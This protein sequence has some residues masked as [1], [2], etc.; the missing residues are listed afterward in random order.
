MKQF[1]VG[2]IIFLL[3]VMISAPA[4]S[5]QGPNPRVRELQSKKD[6]IV[7]DYLDEAV[8]DSIIQAVMEEYHIPG[9]ATSM[10][11][12]GEVIWTGTYGYASFEHA[13]MVTDSTLFFL[14][15]ASNAFT[16]TALMQLWDDGL[17]DLD[18]DINEYLPQELVVRNPS[19]P[20]DP[21][22][23]RMLLTHTS[24]IDY[25][26][27][28]QFNLISW[29]TDCPVPLDS[30]LINYF[31]PGGD[32]YSYGPFNSWAPGMGYEHSF[33][34]YA[35]IGYLVEILADTSFA[36]YCQENIF[37]PLG[38]NKTALFLADLDTNHIAMPYHYDGS[39]Y[40]PY[41]YYGLAA[42]PGEQVR[43]SIAQLARFLLAFMNNG[44]LEGHRILNSAT[45]DS[46]TIVQF[47]VVHDEMGL[48]WSIYE[49]QG[50]QYCGLWG[51][52][53]DSRAAIDYLTDKSLGGV[54]LANGGDWDGLNIIYDE[55]YRFA[56]IFNRIYGY[57]V[58][59]SS[60]Y[61]EKDSGTLNLTNRFANPNQHTF[62][63]QAICISTD[64]TVIDSVDLYDDGDHNDGAAG[65]GIWGNTI[66]PY[67]EEK[68]FRVSISTTD[69]VTEEIFA[70]H[71]LTRFTTIGPITFDHFSCM[72]EDTIAN[73]G[74]IVNMCLHLAN[75][76]SSTEA[77]DIS[78]KISSDDPG[79]DLYN[80]PTIL[81]V[82]DIAAGG[83]A[84]TDGAFTFEVLKDSLEHW[85]TKFFVD[86]AS[87][88]YYFW[89]DTFFVYIVS[90]IE[91]SD[92]NIP[93]VFSLDQNYP[94]PFNPSTTIEFAIPK[95]EFVSIKIYNLLGQEVA[96][97]V[98]QTLK[99]GFYK[100]EW[101]ASDLSS[102]VYYYSIQAGDF[103][104]VKKM[105]LIR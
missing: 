83:T 48:S 9:L 90:G 103:Q 41:G 51:S 36:A 80:E 101:N 70:I 81:S 63:A 6:I 4:F 64:N 29:G 46:M 27:N 79:I 15:G 54:F 55:L 26:W 65:D 38:M 73:Y 16:G 88:G 18:D 35:L 34:G 105:V 3:M 104:D 33:G 11:R 25:D 30:F 75:T 60:N 47:P 14:A 52:L 28:L 97:L 74:D 94:N 72:G 66:G 22:T 93:T 89:K 39:N 67:A 31:M 76:G 62:N 56:K 87:G 37:A 77:S 13:R 10:I 40:I 12:E 98:S 85:H 58:A 1:T 2:L 84:S 95:T 5:D 99:A 86:I 50:D 92:Q 7:K 78:I 42:Y 91:K 61:I 43:T 32:Y 49:W 21:I 102:G 44:E 82:G 57:N 96:T 45:V 23:F 20:D 71:D 24:S 53:L 19:Y 59:L 8:M 100:Y 68:E 17:F 69:E